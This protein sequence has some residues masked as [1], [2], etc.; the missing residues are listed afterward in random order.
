MEYPHNTGG[1]SGLG[2]NGNGPN[3]QQ[4]QANM[5][6]MQSLQYQFMPGG[7]ADMVGNDG[8]SLQQQQQQQQQ[9]WEHEKHVSGHF[10][11]FFLASQI[12]GHVGGYR[13]VL[14]AMV[15]KRHR[16]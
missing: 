6:F 15:L 2:G 14:I 7:P 9:P 1:G 12:G 11:L 4:Q 10:R 13:A 3:Q 8:P 5:N 16:F